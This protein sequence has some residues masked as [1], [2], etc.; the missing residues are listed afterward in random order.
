VLTTDPYYLGTLAAKTAGLPHQPVTSH[1]VVQNSLA[2]GECQSGE[3]ERCTHGCIIDFEYKD[4]SV[5]VSDKVKGKGTLVTRCVSV[6][7][8]HGYS[9]S[10]GLVQSR[11]R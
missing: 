1:P 7:Q 10:D 9:P 3:D 8:L 4:D 5:V 11:S 6:L 2:P